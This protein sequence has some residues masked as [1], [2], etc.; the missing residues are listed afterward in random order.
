MEKFKK[1]FPNKEGF[2]VFALYIILFVFQ[3]V[4]ITASKTENGIYDYNTTLV[5]FLSELLKLFISAALY[6]YKRGDK[7][8]IFKAISNNYNLLL[9]YFIP[10]LLYC[11]YNNLAFI[12]LSH[13]DPTSYYILLQF[14]VVLTAFIFQFLFKKKLAFIQWISLG[15]LTLGCMLKN[16]DAATITSKGDADSIW[17]QIF[18]IYFVSINFQNFCSCLAGTYNEYLLK[19][20]GSNVDIFLQNVFMYLDSVICNFFILMCK[21]EVLTMF[22]DFQSLGDVFVIL[23]TVNSAIVG[24]VTSFFL[25]NLNSILKTYASALELIITAVVC[26]ILFHIL[27]TFYTIVSI[28]LVVISVAMYFKNPVNNTNVESEQMRKDKKPLLDVVVQ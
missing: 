11:F 26:Y 17:S 21:G 2:I 20:K 6:T 16:F 13:Y 28:C 24:I 22:K 14:R 19:T 12:N 9:Q 27:I 3:G 18:N 5:V 15:I 10:S 8:N 25:K 7:P 23:I 1:L 4:F